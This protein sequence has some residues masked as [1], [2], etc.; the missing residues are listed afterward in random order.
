MFL[1]DNLTAATNR[2]VK[3]GPEDRLPVFKRS[4]AS[5]VTVRGSILRYSSTTKGA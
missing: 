3:N 1:T 2:H 4:I 5:L